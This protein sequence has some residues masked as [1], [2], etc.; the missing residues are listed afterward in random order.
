MGQV[1]ANIS[2]EASN[3]RNEYRTQVEL[4][5]NRVGLLAGKDKILMTMYLEN[6]NSF[7]QMAQLAGVNETTISRRIHRVSKR[8]IDGD[9]IVCLRNRDQFTRTQ[10]GIAKDYYLRGMS[11][12]KIAE[13]HQSTYY[14][15]CKTMQDIRQLIK[16][17]R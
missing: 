9:F 15:V 5:R 7:Y 4:L 10:M 1:H 8:L 12:R 3:G 11:I 2:Q 14:R 6:G 13:K 16:S 17:I